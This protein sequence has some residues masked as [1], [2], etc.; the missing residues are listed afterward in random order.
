L[1]PGARFPAPNPVAAAAVALAARPRIDL[2]GQ[3][4][5]DDRTAASGSRNYLNSALHSSGVCFPALFS[6]LAHSAASGGRNLMAASGGRN[7][8]AVSGARNYLDLVCWA[9]GGR[10]SAADVTSCGRSNVGGRNYLG[11]Q[12]PD[13]Q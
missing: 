12:R 3:I 13:L 1:L 7:S 4:D 6:A 9:G 8:T 11:A 2:G 5:L 10:N